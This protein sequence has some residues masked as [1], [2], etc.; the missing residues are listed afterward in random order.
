MS[1][2]I[3]NSRWV[4]LGNDPRV[5]DL[6]NFALFLNPVPRAVHIWEV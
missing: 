6:K 1:L 4:E 5:T 2:S 3:D